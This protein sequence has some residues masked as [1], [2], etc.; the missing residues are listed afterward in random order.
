MVKLKTLAAAILAVAFMASAVAEDDSGW[1][2]GGTAAYGY[3]FENDRD[4]DDDVLWG[5]QIGYRFNSK[6]WLEFSGLVGEAD[7]DNSSASADVEYYQLNALRHFGDASNKVRPYILGGIGHSEIDDNPANGQDDD[8]FTFNFGAGISAFPTQALEIRLGLLGMV[9]EEG[10]NY[11]RMITAGL[12]YHFGRC[13]CEPA[14]EPAP[15][16]LTK[17]V[18]LGVQFDTDKSNVKPQY[19]AEIK[20][21]ADV[22]VAYPDLNIELGGHTDSRGSDSYNQGLSERRVNAV[23]GRLVDFGANGSNISAV[24]YGESQPVAS[25]DTPE[26][27]YA[28][29]RVEAKPITVEVSE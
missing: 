4:L 15:A 19:D 25:N 20:E 12:N 27:R 13:D 3:H 17:T 16:L 18:T 26:G 2:L 9:D 8:G 24:G 21:I 29:R 22:L 1:Y 10:D 14:P 6:W 7:F 28:N 11:D 23:K 5:G